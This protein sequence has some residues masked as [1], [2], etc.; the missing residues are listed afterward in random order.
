MDLR[1]CDLQVSVQSFKKNKGK[2]YL[3]FNKMVYSV[4]TQP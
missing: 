2:C 1:A 3:I 4:L